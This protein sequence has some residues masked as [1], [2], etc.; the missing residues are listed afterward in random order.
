MS[1]ALFLYVGP[2]TGIRRVYLGAATSTQRCMRRGHGGIRSCAAPLSLLPIAD[3]SSPVCNLAAAWR[4]SHARPSV[5]DS[6]PARVRCMGPAVA[7]GSARGKE[8]VVAI[9]VAREQAASLRKGSR[10][11]SAGRLIA[12]GGIEKVGRIVEVLMLGAGAGAV[13]MGGL[14]AATGKAPGDCLHAEG[15]RVK[16]DRRMD[17]RRLAAACALLFDLYVGDHLPP[18]ASRSLPY[19]EACIL[20]SALTPD[21]PSATG[22]RDDLLKALPAL[23]LPSAGVV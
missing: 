3:E 15:K 19:E 6:D 10:S 14:L 17:S 9:V 21:V 11:A 12:D 18:I 5:L 7:V 22:V 2:S 13:M 20:S 23:A 1:T 8:T 4:R 16:T